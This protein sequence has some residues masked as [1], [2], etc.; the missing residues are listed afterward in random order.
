MHGLGELTSPGWWQ[1]QS[2]QPPAPA[3]PLGQQQCHSLCTEDVPSKGRLK[4]GSV[5]G[6]QILDPG[7]WRRK[8]GPDAKVGLQGHPAAFLRGSRRGQQ[9]LLQA[10]AGS[11]A[12]RETGSPVLSVTKHFSSP[13]A[14]FPV[15]LASKNWGFWK[16][17]VPQGHWALQKNSTPGRRC[18]GARQQNWQHSTCRD[19]VAIS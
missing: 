13:R 6:G 10:G 14:M 7:P 4:S 16:V 15:L 11:S 3:R 1:I 17:R 5:V 12:G 8:A 9:L 2:L 18:M 19:T